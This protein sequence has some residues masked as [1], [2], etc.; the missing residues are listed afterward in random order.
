MVWGVRSQGCSET[1][2]TIGIGKQ[3]RLVGL[4]SHL[5]LVVVQASVDC[6]ELGVTQIYGKS[7]GQLREREH[8]KIERNKEEIN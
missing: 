8:G 6:V 4:L 5:K 2:V 1:W 7:S 3:H